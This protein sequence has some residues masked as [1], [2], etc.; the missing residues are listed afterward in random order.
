M[1]PAPTKVAGGQKVWT[2]GSVEQHLRDYTDLYGP[3][4]TAAAFSP[5]TAK[6]RDDPVSIE[7]YYAGNPRTGMA[8]PSLN[9]IKTFFDGSINHAREAI[10]LERNTPG[11]AK[12]RR[13]AGVAAP[14]RDVRERVHRVVVERTADNR[15]PESLSS[16]GKVRTVVERVVETVEI[17]APGDRK[18]R[19]Q[20]ERAE[21]RLAQATERLREARARARDAKTRATGALARVRTLEG[22]LRVSEDAARALRLALNDAEAA[23]SRDGEGLANKLMAEMTG[24]AADASRAQEREGEL[25]AA[26]VEAEARVAELEGVVELVDRDELARA[27]T[28]VEQARGRVAE[29]AAGRRDAEAAQGRAVRER[30]AAVARAEKAERAA[31]SEKA[32]RSKLQATLTGHTRRLSPSEVEA[33]RE[34]GPQ[35]PAVF[36][37]AV[38]A[39]VKAQA[40]GEREALR[41]AL[42]RAASAAIAWSD[43][44]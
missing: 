37:D 24:R 35:G 9:T 28:E 17:P 14:Q 25:H 16:D 7:R 31:A 42:R 36:G 26:L 18:L 29:A 15:L 19:R 39:V 27:A 40:K 32:M 38:K 1:T 3:H 41:A 10:G 30:R 12:H 2:R 23:R 5:S 43:R 11:P 13:A 34:K 8:W 44:L 21:A 22:R 6:W 20:T 33:L 4:W